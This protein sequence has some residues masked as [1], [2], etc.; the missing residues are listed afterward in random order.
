MYFLNDFAEFQ[1]PQQQTPQKPSL[2]GTVK[3]VTLGKTFNGFLTRAGSLGGIYG[4]TK[5]LSGKSPTGAIRRS[6]RLN[7]FKNDALTTAAI[8]I[9][10][11]AVGGYGLK[12][13]YDYYRE[14]NRKWWELL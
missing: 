8:G 3:N 2:L 12:K 4:A 5:L 6:Y 10:T 11:V 9:P 1:Q 14:K 13:G 7:K